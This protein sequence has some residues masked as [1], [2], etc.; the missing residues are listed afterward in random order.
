MIQD[1]LALASRYKVIL[2]ALGVS[3]LLI[4]LI[5]VLMKDMPP[6]MYGNM[7]RHLV[8]MVEVPDRVVNPPE[9]G[10]IQKMPSLFVM[11]RC[12]LGN[13]LFQIGVAEKLKN[14]LHLLN[15]YYL[16]D[17]TSGEYSDWGGHIMEDQTFARPVLPRRF[18]D[19]F[20]GLNV[21]DV[22]RETFTSSLNH[23]LT[24]EN[25]VKVEDVGKVIV[26][27]KYDNLLMDHFFMQPPYVLQC[28]VNSWLHPSIPEYVNT[29]YGFMK[30]GVGVHLRLGHDKGDNFVLPHPT[31]E[32]LRSF[33]KECDAPFLYVCTD[34]AVKATQLLGDI[35]HQIISDMNYVELLAMSQCNSLLLSTSTFSWWIG[36]LSQMRNPDNAKIWFVNHPTLIGKMADRCFEY[37]ERHCG[38]ARLDV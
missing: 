13:K 5:L 33:M 36:N 15:C 4:G 38:W 32:H 8:G 22:S 14:D 31:H 2:I 6:I 29:H 9:F 27:D 20:D 12:G 11:T 3:A 26:E 10:K 7:I 35:P 24:I 17:N 28:D 21:M 19:V 30:G 18:Q 37:M 34:N 23:C 25:P 1:L 16:V